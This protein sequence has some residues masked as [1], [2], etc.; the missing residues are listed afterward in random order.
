[1]R[2]KRRVKGK[3]YIAPWEKAFNSVL[4]PLE[5]FI[6]RQTTSGVLLMLCAVVALI[7]ANTGFYE[8]YHH[9]FQ[10][11]FTVGVEGFQLSK[12]LHHWI[13]DGLMAIFFLVVGLE[14]KRELLVG[15]LSDVKQALLPIIAAVGGMVV[16][17]LIYMGINAGSPTFVGWGIPMATDIAFA[18]GALAL[19]GSRIPTSLLLFLVALAIVDDLGAVIVIALFYTES[20]NMGAMGIAALCVAILISFN[21]GGIRRQSP[22]LFIGAILWIAMLKS[23][24]HATLAGVLLAFTMP[25]KPKY[26]PKRF[27][28]Q[29]KMTLDQIKESYK[30]NANIMVNDE[31]RSRVHHLGEGVNL[32][33]AP[34]QQL[35]HALHL[36]SAYIVI[37]IFALA[38][39]GVPIE[40]GSFGDVLTDPVALG[41]IFGLVVG[42][43]IG[44]AGL[45]WVAV[46]MGLCKLPADLNFN[47]IVGVAFMGG[48]GFTMS[49]FIAELGFAGS[50]HDLL[51]AKTG[52]LFASLVSGLIGFTWLYMM[53]KK[54]VKEPE[55][56]SEVEADTAEPAEEETKIAEETPK[57]AESST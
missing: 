56:E 42:K 12:T 18:L 27:I 30:R 3:E 17:A 36:P 2:P 26:D 54:Q 20:L 55:V 45:S 57:T 25:M 7:I 23:G 37:P 16:P 19:L 11:H 29:M 41:V 35:E 31:L 10:L 34:A 49:I 32:A 5:E 14:L 38:N 6:H 44:I 9:F 15:E 28:C 52:I 24:V 40:F 43:L 4:S 8:Q 21:K 13:N 50:P 46:K 51:M 39:A 47:H 22:Y 1:M 53:T 33:Q 48:I